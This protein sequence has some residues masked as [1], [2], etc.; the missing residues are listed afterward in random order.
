MITKELES[1][2]RNMSSQLDMAVE[3]TVALDT[4]GEI[5]ASTSTAHKYELSGSLGNTKAHLAALGRLAFQEKYGVL[6]ANSFFLLS[7]VYVVSKRVRILSLLA[8]FY[9]WSIGKSGAMDE[10]MSVGT[11]DNI[12]SIIPGL[13]EQIPVAPLKD[14]TMGDMHEMETTTEQGG[15]A[16]VQVEVQTLPDGTTVELD[17]ESPDFRLEENAEQED[18]VEP[19]ESDDVRADE[20]G[21]EDAEQEDGV[22]PGES[23]DVRADE[24]GGEDADNEAN[25]GE[26]RMG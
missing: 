8:L 17:R 4:D 9:R 13:D 10:S 19:G 3:A 1:A 21:D 15:T 14:A 16:H 22:E 12:P 18:R 23:D 20:E 11:V 25:E 5:L 6:V 2:R 24:E 26:E 7:V